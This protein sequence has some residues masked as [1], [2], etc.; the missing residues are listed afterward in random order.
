MRLV[1]QRVRRA[2]VE[3]DGRTVAAIQRGFLVLCGVHREDTSE[4]P[5]YLAQKTARLRVFDDAAGKMN[6]GLDE[7]GGEVLAVS[8]FTLYADCRKGNRPSYIEAAGPE[9]GERLYQA[10][11]E[12]LRGLGVKV[13]TGIFRAMM[14][15]DLVNDGPVTIVIDSRDRRQVGA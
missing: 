9:D 12:A 5:V 11:V 10:Y 3:V 14:A 4:D 6:L 1:I 15:V 13:Q 8:Q 2:S 7:V